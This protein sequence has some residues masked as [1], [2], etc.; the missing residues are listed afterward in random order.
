[1]NT[2]NLLLGTCVV[3]TLVFASLT[4]VEYEQVITL[5]SQVQSSQSK[6]VS[7]GLSFP[8]TES[9]IGQFCK[10]GSRVGGANQLESVNATGQTMTAIFRPVLAMRTPSTTFACVT[11]QISLA[12]APQASNYSAY[13]QT[14]TFALGF[15]VCQRIGQA[16]LG[17]A[18]LHALSGGAYPSQITLSN[19]PP[20]FTVIY[21][22]TST[23]GLTGFFD[24]VGDGFWGYPL[25]VGYQASKLNAS[26]FHIILSPHTTI[27]EPI[28]AISIS[29]IGMDWTYVE[30]QCPPTPP[31]CISGN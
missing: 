2:K 15:S 29:V 11:Y 30:F 5:S 8:H 6:T 26:D 14:I 19:S 22:I 25:A 3:L 23:S 21:N 24:D 28:R 16:G 7:I 18:P 13:N 4:L 9:Q 10:F 12:G 27:W 1:M 17:C 31:V 20:T